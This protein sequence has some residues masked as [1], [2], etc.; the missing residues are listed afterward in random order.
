LSANKR[1]QT[2]DEQYRPLSLQN[3]KI[4]WVESVD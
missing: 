2:I 4:L 3:S 1:K